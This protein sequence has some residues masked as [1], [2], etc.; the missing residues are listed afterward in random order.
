MGR[1]VSSGG[2]QSSLGYLFGSGEPSKSAGDNPNPAPTPAAAAVDN[3]KQIP[4]GIPGN[5][6]NNYFR[7][8]GQ[9]TG[10]FITYLL[11]WRTNV[12]LD[13][14]YPFI[15][16]VSASGK[17][18]GV[19]SD[20]NPACKVSSFHSIADTDG[21][22]ILYQQ[23][24]APDPKLHSHLLRVPLP[25]SPSSLLSLFLEICNRFPFSWRPPHRFHL[26]LL[27]HH[28]S[29]SLSPIAASKLLDVFGKSRNIDL[30]WSHLR[31]MADRR[32]LSVSSLRIAARSLA[33][34]NEIS[35]CVLLFRL[36]PQFLTAG[37]LNSVVDV[38]CARKHVQIA[39][40]VVSKLRDSIPADADTYKLLIIGFCR[41]G[42]LSQAAKLWN[43]MIDEDMSPDLDAYN[44]ILITLF[45]SNATQEAMRF[46]KSMRKNLGIAS[47]RVMID[48]TCKVRRVSY[49]YMV[50]AE[51]IKRGIGFD[52]SVL[53]HL[54][55]GL[56]G[57]K[58]VNEA[59]KVF[60][61]A[62]GVDLSICH[63][64]MKGLLSIRRP[65]AAT[66]VFR[67]MVARGVEP[68]MHTYIMLLQGHM[69]K[70]GRKGKE[71]AVNFDSIFVGGVVKAGNAAEVGKYVERAARG[72]GG[73]VP[74]F[75][76]NKFLHLF[77][78]EEGVKM[79][80]EVGRVLKKVGMVDIGDVLLVYGERMA[81]RERR[82]RA[83][84]GSQV[85]VCQL[86][87]VDSST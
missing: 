79:F 41:A 46:F 56:L 63:G 5:T 6:T 81:T 27:S 25:S 14:F 52:N 31:L 1:G 32:L 8:D 48:W 50:F 60:K 33:D 68:N 75:D 9:N 86:E 42:D 59:Y 54:I 74:R 40:A 66:E 84:W 20:L 13:H 78:N 11:W 69:G 7:A 65:G 47:Y 51:M 37:A 85:G 82:R 12:A 34:A 67:E 18:N 26:F 35:K 87:L 30:L 10:N 64:M 72:G 19:D 83:L 57:K 22:S 23:Q 80:E 53:G 49:A 43:L 3:S 29:F 62:E 71:V 15:I 45:K 44:E 73:D 24:L 55:Y 2:G 58:R 28:P 21:A 17:T 38:I 36:D 16:A 70:R 4:A 61:E 77:S 39:H 76:Y